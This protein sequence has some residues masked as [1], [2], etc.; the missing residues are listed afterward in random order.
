MASM[1]G[2]A[3]WNILTINMTKTED[4]SKKGTEAILIAGKEFMVGR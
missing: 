4:T 1:M 2:F 3:S